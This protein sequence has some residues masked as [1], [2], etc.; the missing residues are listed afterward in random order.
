MLANAITDYI[1]TLNVVSDAF[2]IRTGRVE[3]SET[4]AV[5][6]KLPLSGFNE[7]LDQSGYYKGNQQ[8]IV[9]SPDPEE[10]FAVSEQLQKALTVL[11]SPAQLD[12]WRLSHFRPTGLP[13]LFPLNDGDLYETSLNF[14]TRAA[15][16]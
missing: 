1:K 16:L 11:G 3:A 14:D 6:V 13:L 2:V 10:A 4:R 15:R 7:S 5:M 8:I 12:G 9:R